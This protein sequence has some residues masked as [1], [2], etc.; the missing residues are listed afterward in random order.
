MNFI[1]TTI[2]ISFLLISFN[3]HAETVDT[4]G[5]PITMELD[6]TLCPGEAYEDVFFLPGTYE[7]LLSGTCDTILTVNYHTLK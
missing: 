3:L 2:A 5:A 1:S 4:L 7:I 6:T